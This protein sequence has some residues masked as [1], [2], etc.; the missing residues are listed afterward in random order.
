M[1]Y[2]KPHKCDLLGCSRCYRSLLQVLAMP[3]SLFPSHLL[4]GI[5]TIPSGL[6][7]RVTWRS[8]HTPTSPT[9]YFGCVCRDPANQ[10]SP[11]VQ[12]SFHLLGMTA[13]LCLPPVDSDLVSRQHILVAFVSKTQSP[14]YSHKRNSST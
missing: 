13:L 1:S 6:S 3:S 8:L 5:M 14:A 10:S 12:Y 7:S 11:P 9:F 4:L 2:F